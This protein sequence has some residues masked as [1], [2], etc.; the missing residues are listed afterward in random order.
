MK[1]KWNLQGRYSG[2]SFLL[3]LLLLARMV[4]FFFFLAKDEPILTHHNHSKIIV[5]FNIYSW[6]Y[7]FYQFGQMYN[8][9]DIIMIPYRAVSLLQKSCMLCLFTS[10]SLP[11][12]PWKPLIFLLS[13]QLCILQNVSQLQSY[14]MQPSQIGLF[15]Q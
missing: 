2:G 13:S 9:L 14:S 3:L 15:H 6:C 7:T 5:Y 1:R 4:L 11:T 8:D 10:P 12:Q